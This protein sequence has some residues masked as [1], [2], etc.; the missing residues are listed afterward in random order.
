MD[1]SEELDAVVECGRRSLKWRQ[2]HVQTH[3]NNDVDE[4]WLSKQGEIIQSYPVAVRYANYGLECN[5][6]IMQQL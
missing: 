5:S 3:A 4:C 2:E 1:N 6:I